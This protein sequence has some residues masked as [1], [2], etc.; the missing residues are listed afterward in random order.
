MTADQCAKWMDYQI[1][2]SSHGEILYLWNE[3]RAYY[4]F[5]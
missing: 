4:F 5:L 3:Y 2:A 1:A